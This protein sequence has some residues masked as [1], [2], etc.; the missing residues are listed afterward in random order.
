MKNLY[1]IIAVVLITT[2]VYAQKEN[3]KLANANAPYHNTDKDSLAINGYDL[4]EYFINKKALRGSRMYQYNYQ[5]IKYYFLSVEN[6]SI[7]VKN[8]ETYLPQY[9]GYCAYG[10]GMDSGLI[11][12]LPGKYPINPETFK[13]IDNKLYL[14]YNDNGYNFLKIWE[15]NEKANLQK[16]NDRW[17]VFTDRIKN[18]CKPLKQIHSFAYNSLLFKAVIKYVVV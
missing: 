17:G 5:G 6:K 4:T 9:G 7:F 8:P 18:H 12:N 10:L 1:L 16:A 13:I 11:G 15:E 2:S 3:V 14:F